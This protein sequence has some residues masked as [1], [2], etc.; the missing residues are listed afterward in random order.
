MRKKERRELSR[1]IDCL[2]NSDCKEEDVVGENVIGSEVYSVDLD[3]YGDGTDDFAEVFSLPRVV[4][5][6]VEKGFK[7]SKS[8]DLR[9]GWN[10]LRAEDRKR[11]LEDIDK[12]EPMLVLVCPPCRMYSILQNISRDKGD[13]EEKKRRMIEDRV[14]MDFGIQVYELQRKKCRG[15][16][17]EQPRTATSWKEPKMIELVESEGSFTVDLDQCCFQLRDPVSKK[18]YKKPTRL[19]T[20]VEGVR[21]LGRKCNG[22]HEHEKIEGKVKVGGCW[23]ARSLCAQV[24]PKMLVDGFV[25]VLRG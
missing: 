6:A 9:N 20:N 21:K 8:F 12:D 13:P 14:L 22:K 11:C 7:A 4:P 17:L 1:N 23:Q 3:M 19:V 16:I 15:Y 25:D 24:Y 10:F 5:R 2:L 18:L